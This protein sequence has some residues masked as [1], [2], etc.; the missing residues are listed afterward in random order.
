[1]TVPQDLVP[2]RTFSELSVVDVLYAGGKGANLGQLS[3]VGLAVPPGFVVG[4]PAYAAFR[5]QSGLA[6]RLAEL[7][8]GLDVGDTAA[9]QQA[10]E[11]ARQA[12]RDAPMPDWLASA[13]SNSYEA[14]VGADNDDPV[15]VRSSATA[16]DTA[17][18]S[19]AGL[20]ET[21]LNIRG[22]EAVIDAVER[23]WQL[24]FGARTI[25][26]RAQRGFSRG[27]IDIAV[28]VQRQIPS[29][30]CGVMFTVDPVSG[31]AD[32]LVIEGSFGLGEAVAS[33]QVSPDRYV[34]DK[35]SMAVTTRSVRPKELTI[36]SL[37]G[38][39]T[40]T[41][42][43]NAEESR[44]PVLDDDEVLR[45]AELGVAIEREYGVPQGIEWAFDPDGR[46]WMLQSRPIS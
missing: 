21:F 42:P 34:V 44:E 23:C 17:S 29:T 9:L 3:H 8:H 35:A 2:V 16:E 13:I 46:I 31:N 45:L 6:D 11:Q 20:H 10:S 24:L 43:L 5:V 14:L 28:V 40:A 26:Y 22:R 25:Y 4:A 37:P 30:R 27:E 15:A 1:M 18:A 36:A 39:G 32:Y 41:R 19:S 7:L 33:G 12:V 38:G